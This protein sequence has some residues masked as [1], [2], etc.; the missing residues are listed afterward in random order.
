MGQTFWSISSQT[1]LQ[2]SECFFLV[3]LMLSSSTFYYETDQRKCEIMLSGWHCSLRFFK[4]GCQLHTRFKP[5]SLSWLACSAGQSA[6]TYTTG[7]WLGT[8]HSVWCYY[9]SC[10]SAMVARWLV[11]VDKQSWSI[12]S[13]YNSCNLNS[14]SQCDC[15]STNLEHLFDMKCCK[16]NGNTCPMFI[17]TT[18]GI[19]MDRVEAVSK[20]PITLNYTMVKIFLLEEKQKVLSFVSNGNYL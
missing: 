11:F 6:T 16:L 10:I 3:T 20:M 2:L 18:S 15:W 12:Y 4:L 14:F 5:R 1:V 19:D 9:F 13:V 17:D 8:G 7:L